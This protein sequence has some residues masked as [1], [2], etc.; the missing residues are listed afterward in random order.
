[1]A[2]A[3]AAGLIPIGPVPA[4]FAAPAG[5]LG[6]SSDFDGDGFADAAFAAPREGLGD[7]PDAG[8]VHVLSGS[9]AGLT[10]RD[11]IVIT[12]TWLGE[13]AESGD[14]F[15][16]ALSSADFDAD[17]FADLVVGAPF[18]DLVTEDEGAAT[19]IYGSAEGLTPARVRTFTQ[20]TPGIANHAGGGDQFGG[21]FGVGDLN[22]DGFSDLAIGAREES[23]DEEQEGAGAAHV[24]TVP[25]PGSA[26]TAATSSCKA[27]T[28]CP[29]RRSRSI[30]SA[31]PWRPPT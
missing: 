28:A 16:L 22:G 14:L 3:V 7:A 15:G 6:V 12:Q 13:P 18:E 2:W 17:G 11:D 20:D 30:A 29:T 23:P 8:A 5:G 9:P 26:R 25:P 21:S 31:S 24:P 27:W 19:V 4:A 1:M 10:A